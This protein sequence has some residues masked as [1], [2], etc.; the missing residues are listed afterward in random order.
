MLTDQAVCLLLNSDQPAQLLHLR[1]QFDLSAQC[2]LSVQYGLPQTE[3]D[4]CAQQRTGQIAQFDL[5]L[6]LLPRSQMFFL[7]LYNIKW[8]ASS[9]FVSSSIPS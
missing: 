1:A 3:S 4:Q 9:E 6:F 2:G 8:A 5:C 7:N